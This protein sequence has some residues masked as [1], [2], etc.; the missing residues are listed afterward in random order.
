MRRPYLSQCLFFSQ[1]VSVTKSK[2]SS[3][4]ERN[5]IE[6]FLA[7]AHQSYQY[8]ASFEFIDI[9]FTN[10][11]IE[12]NISQHDKWLYYTTYSCFKVNIA[13]VK[14]INQLKHVLIIS[15]STYLLDCIR[16]K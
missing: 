13:L 9:V 5:D 10:A 15:S 8:E 12:R 16:I 7:K 6:A 14:R 2:I 3:F 11:R 1:M 4:Q